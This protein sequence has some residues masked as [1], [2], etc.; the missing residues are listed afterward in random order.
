M[1]GSTL[2]LV[3]LQSKEMPVF[4]HRIKEARVYLKEGKDQFFLF[5]LFDHSE[6]SLGKV[7]FGSNGPVSCE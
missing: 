5:E 4:L 7:I 2:H 3:D 1:V 6:K